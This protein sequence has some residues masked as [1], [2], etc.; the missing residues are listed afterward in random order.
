MLGQKLEKQVY[1][2]TAQSQGK[3]YIAIRIYYIIL[4]NNHSRNAKK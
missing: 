3:I 4:G 2:M 1:F